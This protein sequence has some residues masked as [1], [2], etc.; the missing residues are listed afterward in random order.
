[1]RDGSALSVSRIL[2]IRPGSSPTGIVLISA[3]PWDAADSETREAI[4]SRFDHPQP[5]ATPKVSMSPTISP[6]D[7]S[8]DHRRPAYCVV[9]VQ[10]TTAPTLG[11]PEDWYRYTIV[12]GKSRITGL[13]RGTLAEVTEYA[14]ECADAFNVRSMAKNASGMTWT[15]RKKK[16]PPVSEPVEK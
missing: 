3:D 1:M 13:H 6:T 11:K 10:K 14:E 2:P 9:S 5:L 16:R 8:E 7:A 4:H 15:S 12:G